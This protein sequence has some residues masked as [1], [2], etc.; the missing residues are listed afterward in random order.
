MNGKRIAYPRVAGELVDS[1]NALSSCDALPIP[2]RGEPRCSVRP[3]PPDGRY[4]SRL[5]LVVT[6]GGCPVRLH[7]DGGAVEAAV[8][9]LIAVESFEAL[10][11]ELKMAVL[12]YVLA[13]PLRALGEALD[14]RV[15]LEGVLPEGSGAVGDGM[16]GLEAAPCGLLVAVHGPQDEVRCTVMVELDAPLPESVQATLARCR[17]SRDFGEVPVRVTFEAGCASV[18]Q[19]DLRDL[20]PGDIVLFDHCYVADD[21]LRVNVSGSGFLMGRLAGRRVTVEEHTSVEESA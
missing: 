14:A 3:V 19:A 1:V 8:G 17:P 13:A 5:T 6:V 2:S 21:R 9:E 11:P 18:A 15:A 20:A 16:R 7:L 12:E 4:R 10:D